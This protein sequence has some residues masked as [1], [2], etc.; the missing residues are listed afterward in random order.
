MS[1]ERI[2]YLY[3]TIPGIVPV[4]AD[5]AFNIKKGRF[6]TNKNSLFHGNPTRINS[7]F[8]SSDVEI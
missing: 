3:I 5:Y 2:I 7:R 1:I 4:S 8:V 6:L